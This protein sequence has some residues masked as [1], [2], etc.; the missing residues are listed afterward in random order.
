MNF[1][2]LKFLLAL[3]AFQ[4]LYACAA[5]TNPHEP[6]H[7]AKAAL[8]SDEDVEIVDGDALY[9]VPKKGAK[10]GF[11]F[12][13]G[14]YVPPEAYAVLLHEIAAEGY[15][16]VAPKFAFNLAVTG[17]N[18]TEGVLEDFPQITKWA[19][20]GHSLGGAMAAHFVKKNEGAVGALIL[21]AAY[22]S[23]T[24]DL[25]GWAGQVTSIS[26]S[27]DGLSTPEKIAASKAILPPDTDYVVIEGGNH[28]Q[29]GD[30]GEQKGDN[31]ARISPDDQWGQIISATLI[32]LENL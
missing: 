30:Y 25:S 1:K 14:A 27:L 7:N 21:W 13:T 17:A 4:F 10:A 19:I 12:Y 5:I 18:H 22:P 2:F 28:A 16:V 3:L 20:G 26:A 6:G 24:D 29:F 15:L 9:F 8:V 11:V 32:A 31:P 23:K